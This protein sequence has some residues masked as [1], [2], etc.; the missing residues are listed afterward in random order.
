L[1][2]ALAIPLQSPCKL[3]DGTK[4]APLP[5]VRLRALTFAWQVFGAAYLLTTVASGAATSDQPDEATR[6]ARALADD[7]AN[8]FAQG[9]Y[10][11]SHELLARA[12]A[13]VQAPTIAILEARALVRLG[14]FVEARAAYERAASA[15]LADDAPD[16]F[17]TAAREAREE[18]VALEWRIPKCRVVHRGEDGGMRV[19]LDGRRLPQSSLGTWL[20][21]NPGLHEVRAGDGANTRT[22]TFELREGEAETV[23]IEPPA[24][25]SP[26]RTPAIVAFGTGAAGLAVGITTGIAA[27]NAHGDAERGCPDDTCVRGSA[28]A[29]AYERFESY[30]L[31]ST[32]GYAVGVVGVG[33]GVALW[34]MAPSTSGSSVALVSS[35]RD[36]LV[37]G[38]F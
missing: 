3:G 36:V 21:V 17:T 12:Y 31:L 35:F 10:E 4:G 16:A 7:G 32:I 15:A 18:L 24:D 6:R 14:R 8:A 2:P 28:G 37:E 30:R 1:A 20:A 13:I 29:E 27:V 5:A 23:R 19:Y 38:T 26:S 9:H 34:L 22:F 11:L 33:A 25:T